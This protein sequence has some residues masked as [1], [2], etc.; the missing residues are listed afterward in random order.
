MADAAEILARVRARGANIVMDGDRLRLVGA[1]KLSPEAR[2]F[3]TDHR[4][5]IVEHLRAER[6]AEIEERAA[7]IEF[8]GKAPREWA[9]QFAQILYARR[10]QGVSDIEWSWFI[11]TCGRIIDEAP[12]RS[13][14]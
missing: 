12:A 4:A 13:V 7:V 3:V 9:E 6:D 11:T 5:A 10:P 2:Q 8:E 1:T 14:A